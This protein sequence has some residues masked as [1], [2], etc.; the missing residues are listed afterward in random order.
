MTKQ[1][2]IER[3]VNNN[4]VHSFQ[5]IL[6]YKETIFGIV[7]PEKYQYKYNFNDIFKKALR[8]ECDK[9]IL[10]LLEQNL[11]E[12]SSLEPS[13]KFR[14]TFCTFYNLFYWSVQLGFDDLTKFLLKNRI[15]SIL[16]S[17]YNNPNT[18]L[19]I[20]NDVIKFASSNGNIDIVKFL[21]TLKDDEINPATEDNY[22]I[23]SAASL[24]HTDVVRLLLNDKR[25]DPSARYNRALNQA[26]KNNHYTIA[27]LLYKNPRTQ[28]SLP[29]SMIKEYDRFINENI[30]DKLNYF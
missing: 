9:I 26:I 25:V 6:G 20:N 4:N 24:G 15:N 8:E 18:N 12:L 30:E 14:N 23:I 17:L 22:S 13:L 28:E 16:Y 5:E 2:F 10:F 21:L 11:V 27:K 29:D 1:G 19:N 7:K 3:E